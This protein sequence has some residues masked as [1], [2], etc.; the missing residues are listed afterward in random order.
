MNLL[1]KWAERVTPAPFREFIPYVSPSSLHV[2]HANDVLKLALEIGKNAFSRVS[3]AELLERFPTPLQEELSAAGIELTPAPESTL[4]V[5]DANLNG[6]AKKEIGNR[7]LFLYFALIHHAPYLPL[8]LRLKQFRWDE[9]SGKL[10]FQATGFGFNPSP[11][12]QS[13]LAGLYRGF[14]FHDEAATQ[15]GLDLY[16]WKSKPK[17]GYFDRIEGLLRK[18]FGTSERAEVAFAMP[19]FRESFHAIFEEAKASN[20]KLHPELAF[21]GS[22]LV[23]LYLS[24]DAL[25]QTHPVAAIYHSFMNGFLQGHATAPAAELPGDPATSDGLRVDQTTLPPIDRS[26]SL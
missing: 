3:P 22:L 6:P 5:A 24:L 11:E 7:I 18:H 12:L 21:V 14:F 16:A 10:Y 13:G 9:Q 20:A 23:T 1:Q 8:D 2:V 25:G 4:A 17:T 26:A 19:H 15:S